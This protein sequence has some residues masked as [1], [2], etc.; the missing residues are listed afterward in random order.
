ME[1]N[2]E[3][4]YLICQ[5]N[6]KDSGRN[7]IAPPAGI[8]WIDYL[9]R[10]MKAVGYRVN[11]VSYSAGIGSSYFSHKTQE[12]DE[13]EI[14][15]YLPAL[16]SDGISI[17]LRISQL[18]SFFQ[19][20]LF[21]L[22]RT[23]C[24]DKIVLYHDYGFSLFM[25]FVRRF[26]KRNYIIILGEFY[27]AVYNKGN[28]KL[29]REI[30]SVE[31]AKGYIIANSMMLQ[32]VKTAHNICVC[33]G[34]YTYCTIQRTERENQVPLHVVY[35]G[36][37]SKND[38]TDAFVAAEIAR[39]VQG[40]FIFHIL[41][42]GTESDINELKILAEEINDERGKKIV[43]YD[44]CLSGS[45]YDQFLS[46][47]DIGLCT[48]TLKE[49]SCNLCFPSKTLVYLT[50][51]LNVICPKAEFILKSDIA[52]L[53]ICV[54]GDMNPQKIAECLDNMEFENKDFTDEFRKIDEK[55]KTSLVKMVRAV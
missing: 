9:V 18:F 52:T 22:R 8:T 46:R 23:K 17:K 35:A 11:I 5:Y 26:V 10:S 24:H 38:I 6:R 3:T 48:R 34:D 53:V 32:Y 31:G 2:S 36:K 20:L 14:V 51:G 40:D 28:D 39:H 19:I 44:G 25:H 49:P 15:H 54:E 4:I 33:H 41:G 13:K 30:N 43:S 7:V 47:C 1:S 42:Y 50:H 29:K 27:S 16:N 55:F 37:I 21:L 45:E 12:V